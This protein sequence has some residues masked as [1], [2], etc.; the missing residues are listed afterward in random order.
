LVAKL[1]MTVIAGSLLPGLMVV[2]FMRKAL[3]SS[4]ISIFGTQII[5]S[6]QRIVKAVIVMSSLTGGISPHYL[7]RYIIP[8]ENEAGALITNELSTEVIL[9]EGTRSL[10]GAT[11]AVIHVLLMFLI[12]SVLIVLVLKVKKILSSTGD[13]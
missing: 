12:F 9:F 4:Y 3:L 11:N 8:S 2:F 6:W 13:D 5:E 10:L 7:E 1:L